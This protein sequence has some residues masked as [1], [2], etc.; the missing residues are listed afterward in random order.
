MISKAVPRPTPDFLT[1]SWIVARQFAGN[2]D[3]WTS[4]TICLW[5][6]CLQRDNG[7]KKAYARTLGYQASPVAAGVACGAPLV[8]ANDG[9]ESPFQVAGP[10]R[11]SP[12]TRSYK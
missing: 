10:V 8:A 4:G 1:H 2:G 7:P 12:A 11:I 5:G 9:M 3:N 6:A